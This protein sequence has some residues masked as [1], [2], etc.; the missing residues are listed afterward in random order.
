[1]I[2]E[3][4]EELATFQYR[5]RDFVYWAFPWGEPNSELASFNRLEKWQD[6]LF[7]YLQERME[8][9]KA[10]RYMPIRLNVTSGHGV[11]KLQAVSE[12]VL[13]EHGWRAIG[14][15]RVGD[16][17]ATVDG[18][19]TAVTGVYP[20]G[21][22]PMYRVTLDDGCTTLAGGEHLWLTDTR[23]E[24]KRGKSG[25][26]RT[27]LEIANT[28][29][30]PNGPR[31]GLNHRVPTCAPISHK[32]RL[33]L[34]DPYALGVWLGDGSLD[35]RVTSMDE[36]VRIAVG[37]G[38]PVYKKGNR[39]ANFTTVVQNHHLEYLGLK[40][41]RSWEKFIPNEYFFGSIAQR[42]ALLQGL[43]DTDGTVGKNNAIVFD[44]TSK[45]LA[46][47]VA[48]LVRS[49]G[50]VARRSEKQGKVYGVDK[51]WVYRVFVSLPLDITPFRVGRKAKTYKPD[52]K[53]KNRQRVTSRFVK[54]V[55][56]VED[57]KAVCITVE[58]PSRLYITRDYIV[59][60][61]SMAVSVLNLW[62]FST[63][64]NTRGVLTAGTETQLKTKTWVEMAKWKRLFIAEQLFH[65]T[66]T[67][68]FPKEKG[69]TKEWRLDIVP[70]SENNPAAF[71]GLHNF[72]KRIIVCMDE[73]SEIPE[74]IHETAAGAETDKDTEII[75]VLT[76]NPTD[77]DSFF[78]ECG[79]GGKFAKMWW[80]LQVASDDV[81][82]T[83]HE[84]IAQEREIWGEDSDYFRVRRLGLFPRQSGDSFIP[85]ELVEG[86]MRRPVPDGQSVYPLIMGVDVGRKNDPTVIRF[87]RGLDGSSVPKTVFRATFD[88]AV[89]PTLQI[90]TTIMQQIALYDPEV[91]FI[92]IGH[93]GAAV[94]DLLLN[95]SLAR[96]LFYPVDFGSKAAPEGA[97][98]EMI[99]YVNKRAQIWGRGRSWLARGSMRWD[100]GFIKEATTPTYKFQGETAILLE[101]KEQ[102]KVRL[103]GASTDDADAFFITFAEMM[104][105][106]VQFPYGSL[107]HA[108]AQQ[109]LH[110]Y[111]PFSEENIY[112]RSFH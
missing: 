94:Y 97:A 53:H 28:L 16:K 73:A 32:D 21:V 70:W 4:L 96:P 44:V 86:A 78:R 20:Q 8:E 64:E 108:R 82:L 25:K 77:P 95:K 26:V 105:I 14:D 39:A 101:S 48:T 43:L 27:T 92:D 47:G 111:N 5:P 22:M 6:A 109:Q 61:N 12:P 98:E 85:R 80:S 65:L 91:V 54:M 79:V 40:G 84:L 38:N 9:Y 13:T 74:I 23:G 41:L 55:E 107:R 59:T 45:F 68:L 63:R 75:R 110:D 104:D 1:M 52:W 69:P 58:H 29:T 87:R 76:G 51:R 42:E 56:R 7:S 35:G 34:I 49:L 112:G 33:F 15:L 106:P 93:I 10:G 71:A 89:A 11:G 19:F 62:A 90:L 67:A 103:D 99:R 18:S 81:S 60:H 83:N 36:E 72:G 88:T 57:D 50:G 37:G 100:D 17:V 31:E 2:D 24:R 102:I 30:F 3:L 66:A 46:D